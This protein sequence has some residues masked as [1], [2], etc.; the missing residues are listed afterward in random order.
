MASSSSTSSTTLKVNDVVYVSSSIG[1]GDN[2]YDNNRNNDRLLEGVIQ[3]V[4]ENRIGVLLTDKSTGEGSLERHNVDGSGIIS[5][6]PDRVTKR[7]FTSRLEELRL[8]RELSG[9]TQKFFNDSQKSVTG[10][11][12]IS[13]TTLTLSN[14][15]A[16]F[17]NSITNN[18]NDDSSIKSRTSK[19]RKERIAMLR[20]KRMAMK[21]QRDIV[22]YTNVLQNINKSKK[23][24]ND[25]VMSFSSGVSSITS[26]RSR[27]SCRSS[28]NYLS[29]SSLKRD[30]RLKEKEIL[31]Q[32]ATEASAVDLLQSRLLDLE[33][34]NAKLMET[35]KEREKEIAR[36]APDSYFKNVRSQPTK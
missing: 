21:Q 13:G 20:E 36:L 32:S 4:E 31:E 33:E 12:S 16:N 1:D 30:Y 8:R 3:H 10:T 11:M 14:N 27:T 17:S 19:E 2:N 28:N 23:E 9:I 35:M 29:R 15:I 24:D 25:E 22:S 6:T 18:N 34:K 26:C 5:V 7:R